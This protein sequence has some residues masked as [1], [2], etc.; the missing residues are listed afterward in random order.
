[1]KSRDCRICRRPAEPPHA[2]TPEGVLCLD[3]DAER[4]GDPQA[5]E[6]VCRLVAAGAICG[7]CLE[8]L[9]PPGGTTMSLP[10]TGQLVRACPAC[11]DDW[12]HRGSGRIPRRQGRLNWPHP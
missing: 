5:Y 2:V 10:G 8:E 3:C 9:N 6:G 7:F 12:E 4:R 1:M 11:K